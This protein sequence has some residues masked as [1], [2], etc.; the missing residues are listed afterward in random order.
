MIDYNQPWGWANPQAKAGK[1]NT[2]A[3]LGGG[4]GEGTPAPIMA[5]PSMQDQL[6]Q[7]V[8]GAV[9]NTAVDSIAKGVS[10]ANQLGPLGDVVDATGGA[11]TAVEAAGNTL[12]VTGVLGPLGAAMSGAMKGEYDQAAGAAAGSVIGSMFGGPLGGMLG[13]KLGGFSGNALGGM[14]GLADGT[15]KVPDQN[16]SIV[17]SIWEKVVA[18]GEGAVKAST[19]NSGGLGQAKKAIATRG[20]RLAEEERKAMGYAWGTT[21]AGGKGFPMG[22][23]NTN[24]VLNRPWGS[25]A[26]TGYYGDRVASAGTGAVTY[27]PNTFQPVNTPQQAVPTVQA[28]QLQP[29]QHWNNIWEYGGGGPGSDGGASDGGGGGSGAAGNAGNDGSNDGPSGSAG[30]GSAA[31]AGDGGGGGGGGK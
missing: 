22:G 5:E 29:Q 6:M 26:A 10:Q 4:G 20:E 31:A 12:P 2:L 24:T 13:A 16:K 1:G 23:G 9:A 30:P 21:N 8:G 18:K 11:E 7:K 14:F 17:Q 25:T 15:T 27:R 19:G 3:P 28:P